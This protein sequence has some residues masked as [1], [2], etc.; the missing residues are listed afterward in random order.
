M[1]SN[2]QNKRDVLTGEHFI[3][4][5][6]ACAEGAIAG[7][8]NF[9]AGYPITPS[10]EVAERIAR[11]FNQMGAVFLQMEDEL[12]SING[13]LGGAWGGCKVMTATSGPGFSLMMEG[14][15]H[16]VMTETPCVI[17]DVQRAGPATG[18]PTMVG[19]QDMMQV[20][21]GAHGDFELIAYTPNSAQEMFDLTYK[22]FNMSE[23]YRV[24]VFIMS[25]EII[26]HMMEKVV[27]PS[28]D[29]LPVFSR[30][31]PKTGHTIDYLPFAPEYGLIPA[32]PCA[33]E[34]Y[35]VH[36]TGLTHDERGYPV[37][38]AEAQDKLIRRLTD[39][40][41][42]NVD[43]I[44]EVEEHLTQDAEYLVIAYGISSRTSLNAVRAARKEGIKVG[45]LR[46]ITAWPFP[47]KHIKRLAPQLK[48][49][50]FPEINMGQMVREVERCLRSEVPV[51]PVSHPGGTIHEPEEILEKIRKV[52]RS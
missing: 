45:L 6:V 32:M 19:Q 46:L 33:G 14:I 28:A 44:V 34:G 27:I 35:R 41:R 39:K 20:R 38:T 37:M 40:I 4:G 10:T 25:D 15:S 43:D 11:R 24:P 29:Q 48:G 31:K 51:Y 8:C 17:V 13:I 36:V 1:P 42:L 3:T 16:A 50:I 47:E 7:G 26:G 30:L 22:A 23:K 21:W 9:F 52:A 49:V 5:D 18:L 2:L 12:A